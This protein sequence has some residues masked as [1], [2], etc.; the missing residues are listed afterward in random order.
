MMTKT[1]A[2]TARNLRQSAEEQLQSDVALHVQPH[3]PLEVKKLLHELR[4]HQIELEM[5]NE[6]LCLCLEEL[7]SSR[8]RYF[9]LYDLAPVGYLTVC[10]NG[11][12]REA[13]L[14]SAAM[15]GIA[16]NDLIRKL[17]SQFVS[18]E[19]KTDFYLIKKRVVETGEVQNREM[20]LIKADGVLFWANL[21]A[22]LVLNG[23]YGIT[24]T[25]TTKFKQVEQELRAVLV[26]RESEQLFRNMFHKHSAVML[27]V[28]PASGEIV[29]ANNAA[30]EFYGYTLEQM[31]TMNIADIHCLSPDLV[32]IERRKALD[33]EINFPI[34]LHKLSSGEIRTVEVHSTPMA[35]NDRTLLF[36][37]IHDITERKL[38]EEREKKANL[39]MAR[40]KAALELA[41]EQL[42]QTQRALLKSENLYRTVL[43]SQTEVIARYLPDG[44]N[45][46]V[47][48]A[49]CRYFGKIT[50]QLIGKKLNPDTYPE[51]TPD[52]K[53]QLSTLTV[54]NPVVVIEN[55]VY[56]ATGEVRWMQFVNRGFFDESGC[57]LETQAVGRDVTERKEAELFMA[58][59]NEVLERVVLARTVA[60]EQANK[61]MK[62][63]SFELIW[64]EEKERERIAGELHDQVGQSLLLA[65][66]KFEALADELQS[67]TQ[68]TSAEKAI[69]LI[70]T[71]I[72]DIRSLTFK[73]RPPL[74]ESSNIEKNLQR[75]CNLINDEYDIRVVFSGI[76][77]NI[78]LAPELR[79]VIYCVVRELLL[80]VVKHANTT[81]AELSLQTDDS[82]NL[83]VRVIDHGAGY[84]PSEVIRE[85]VTDDGYGLFNARRRIK[86]IGGSLVVQSVAG[87]GTVVT[88][89]VPI[90]QSVN[91]TCCH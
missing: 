81:N 78:P 14:T 53:A 52:V 72:Q 39:K 83:K 11:L 91:D 70:D 59:A 10:A 65:K 8:L 17:F 79:Y 86:Q 51:D 46:Y 50:H 28:E 75:L 23:E 73:I 30:T 66:M 74:L 12:I 2:E 31:H 33:E 1:T 7:E 55:R 6:E 41:N 38:A 26:L 85:H 82:N 88:L 16:R 19:D 57:L 45:S 63:V 22:S 4:V 29:N 68:R 64:A 9:N 27:L 13:N 21:Q 84:S 24:I 60:L 89:L 69:L 90:Q 20:R 35:I 80:N 47:N 37:I 5:Q 87:A 43:E 48:D 15:L 32:E 56:N 34:S 76:G 54:D 18:L 71:S 61:E 3:S 40:Q 77:A 62:Q 25:D 49:Y 44:T 58:E 42:K 36:S 67:E